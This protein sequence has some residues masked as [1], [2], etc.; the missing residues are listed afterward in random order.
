MRCCFQSPQFSSSMAPRPWLTEHQREIVRNHTHYYIHTLYSGDRSTTRAFLEEFYRMWFFHYPIVPRLI[1]QN[2]LPADVVNRR[3]METEEEKR[4]I[5][6]EK[7][8]VERVSLFE[9]ID[10]SFINRLLETLCRNT[11]GASNHMAH[12][13]LLTRS[14]SFAHC[15]LYPH[16]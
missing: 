12:H 6:D 15:P 10:I 1:E 5:S 13:G 16:S 9:S 11:H 4:I 14:V 2:K 3:N 7:N 8:N